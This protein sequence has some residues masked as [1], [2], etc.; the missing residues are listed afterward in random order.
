MGADVLGGLERGQAVEGRQR[1]VG[2]DEVEG[3]R[4]G[5]QEVGLGLDPGHVG[6]EAVTFE[7]GLHELRIA[8]VVLEM[9][10]FE[11][12]RHASTHGC[13]PRRMLPGGGWLT[14]AQKTPSSLMA[15]T[16]SWKSTGLTT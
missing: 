7:G 14:T 2:Q 13:A 8:H 15:L 5:A 1:F 3:L 11:R 9:Q 4:E 6:H 10:H 16:N 12:S